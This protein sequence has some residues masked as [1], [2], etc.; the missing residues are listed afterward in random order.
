MLGSEM[1]N[2]EI[3]L[4]TP[5]T[6]RS[7]TT[8][9]PKWHRFNL[10]SKSNSNSTIISSSHTSSKTKNHAYTHQYNH[11]YTH[12]L[13]ALRTRCLER[14]KTEN[15]PS[16]EDGKAS[17]IT[18]RIIELKEGVLS[19]VVGTIVKDSPARPVFDTNYHSSAVFDPIGDAD[20]NPLTLQPLRT[21]ANEDNDVVILED[22]S[23]RVELKSQDENDTIDARKLVTGMVVAVTGIV[24]SNTGAL[25]VSKIHYPALPT[26]KNPLKST[27]NGEQDTFS[28]YSP[29]IMIVSGLHCGG[30]GMQY[31]DINSS[32]SLRRS[33][34][35]DYIAGHIYPNDDAVKI[36]R[37]IIAGGGCCRPQTE[38]SEK[39]L[40]NQKF[41]ARSNTTRKKNESSSYIKSLALSAQ[42]LDMFITEICSSG[43]PVD[44][45]PGL[46]DPTNAN[47]PQQPLHPCLLPY[48]S[49]FD[50][51]DKGNDDSGL[52]HRATNPYQAE[53]GKILLLGS[54]GKNI[55]DFRR[56]T[57]SFPSKENE[58]KTTIK[59]ED[60]E[61]SDKS[62]ERSI[63]S[64]LEALEQT[65]MCN[66]L[67]PTAPD[68]LRCFP[69]YD[70]DP[71]V[72]D[73]CPH[74]YFTGNS[75][76]FE[77]K[78]FFDNGNRNNESVKCR[79]VC[80]PSFMETGEAVLVNLHTLACECI[81]FADVLDENEVEK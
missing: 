54:D 53:V 62:E 65:L 74:I 5:K 25:E 59:K 28:T 27:L 71:F 67:A 45:I 70:K 36:S 15:D 3:N 39:L 43:I 23:G 61:T 81:S 7:Y 19:T 46:H 50:V 4:S 18:P 57:S 44:L 10:H 29:Y 73:E 8:F 63:M 31:N 35:C 9:T 20:Q 32:I 66:H 41:V 30:T 72:I 77:T 12:R 22:E 69:F 42:E 38:S 76:K 6:T 1:D 49:T 68:S 56:Y 16:L 80:V 48:S 75:P 11:M 64:P 78:M 60:N 26:Q 17:Q 33:M 79:L 2:K 47:L 13:D 14:A 58:S 24:Q 51:G 37:L 21:Y 52:F 40:S 34:L 55:T